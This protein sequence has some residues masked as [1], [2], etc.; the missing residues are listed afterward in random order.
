MEQVGCS[1]KR[2]PNQIRTIAVYCA[3]V[4]FTEFKFFAHHFEIIKIY[5][6][7]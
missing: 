1:W 7:F 4:K 5:L 6:T 2:I 3:M